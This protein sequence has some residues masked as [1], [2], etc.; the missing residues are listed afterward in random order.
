MH[1][2]ALLNGYH[3]SVNYDNL[4][5]QIF[6]QTV[7]KAVPNLFVD[8]REANFSLKKNRF[9]VLKYIDDKF[10][11]AADSTFEFIIYYKELNEIIHWTQKT[12]IHAKTSDTEYVVKHSNNT[13]HGFEGI[14]L[15]INDNNAAYL[16]GQ[17]SSTDWWFSIGLK[18]I[19]GNNGIPG[20]KHNYAT[21]FKN[22]VV[23]EVSMWVR[24]DNMSLLYSLPALNRICSIKMQ[25]RRPVSFIVYLLVIVSR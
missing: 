7:T 4:F 25:M 10:R 24:V 14:G 22:Q 6:R 1:E 12:S 21:G 3:A 17:P 18:S 15:S 23:H 20:S 5:V 2:K 19:F 13:L 16:D 9:S 8:D 11:I